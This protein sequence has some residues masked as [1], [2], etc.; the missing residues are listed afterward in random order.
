MLGDREVIREVIAQAWAQSPA[1]VIAAI[2]LT[3]VAVLVCWFLLVVAI[4]AGTP[5]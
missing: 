4:V 3:P 5:A 2:A 1:G